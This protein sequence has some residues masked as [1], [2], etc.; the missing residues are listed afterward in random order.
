MRLLGGFNKGVGGGGYGPVITVGGL[1]AGIPVKSMVAIT[2]LAEG[3]TCL[4][5]V[6]V[7]FALLT[8]GVVIDY[9]LLPSFVIGTVIAAVGAPY[10]TRIISEKAWK[11]IV[12]SYCCVLAI[13]AFYKLWPSIQAHF[14]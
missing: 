10:V 14:F 1:L 12:P 7:W 13:Y 5:A 9:M 8:S 4:F 6:I 2:S 3:A 11:I